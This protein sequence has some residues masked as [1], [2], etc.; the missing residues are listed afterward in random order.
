VAEA[1]A[2]FHVLSTDTNNVVANGGLSFACTSIFHSASPNS[3]TSPPILCPI[4]CIV[5]HKL[6]YSSP[7][8]PAI[9]FAGIV[10]I[11]LIPLAALCRVRFWAARIHRPCTML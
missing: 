4:H 2:S 8:L 3:R 7:S 1:H 11:I 9:L 10:I 6:L 5:L